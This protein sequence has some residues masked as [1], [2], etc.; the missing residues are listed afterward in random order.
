MP[1]APTP[2]ELHRSLERLR[3]DLSDAITRAERHIS[4]ESLAAILA[5][6]DDLLRSLGE[7]IAQERGLRE[8]DVHALRD[9]AKVEHERLIK[10]IEA[11][12][13]KAGAQDSERRADR[14]ILYAAA[15]ALVANILYEILNSTQ[16]A[17]T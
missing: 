2:W 14:R 7:D 3:Q 8:A 16:G 6:Y 4:T 11:I 17:G 15:A 13:E 10:E 5:R 1:D 9:W 12:K